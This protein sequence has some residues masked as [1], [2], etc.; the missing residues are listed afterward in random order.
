MK[1]FKEMKD[2]IESKPIDNHRFLNITMKDDNILDLEVSFL[3]PKESPYEEII[4][5]IS[6]TLSK[7][8]PIKAPTMVFKNTIYHPNISNSGVICIDI[9]KNKWTPIYT[10]Q[11][12]L[13]SIISLLNDPN[14]DSPLN[15]IAAK[16]YKDSLK[17]KEQRR[18]Y[19]KDIQY[20]STSY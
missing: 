14:P 18:K 2:Y 17:S 12:T 5:V 9:L 1:E 6:I 7:E 20:I 8:Y 3:G 16:G 4:S 10:L 11:L 19:V 13:M 15:G